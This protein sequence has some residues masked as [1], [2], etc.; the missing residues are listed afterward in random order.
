MEGVGNHSFQHGNYLI[1]RRSSLL[2]PSNYLHTTVANTMREEPSFQTATMFTATNFERL[3]QTGSA[4]M[5]LSLNRQTRSETKPTTSPSDFMQFLAQHV[6]GYVAAQGHLCHLP[7]LKQM[8]N[9]VVGS[10]QPVTNNAPLPTLFSLELLDEKEESISISPGVLLCHRVQPNQGT[11]FHCFNWDARPKPNL[12]SFKRK[13]KSSP[14]G[15]Y[16]LGTFHCE[17]VV[18]SRTL[19]QAPLPIGPD[20][21]L[22][23]AALLPQG[24]ERT[25]G[26][27]PGQQLDF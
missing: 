11:C 19:S 25:L 20:T 2:S 17:E 15:P 27:C 13:K 3:G 7:V 5:G 6:Q 22:V 12:G 16:L 26:L 24:L 18:R 14:Y 4:R 8:G 10:V 9:C 1:E 23:M 21:T